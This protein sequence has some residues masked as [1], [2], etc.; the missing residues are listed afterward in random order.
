MVALHVITGSNVTLGGRAGST[1]TTTAPGPCPTQPPAARTISY[2]AHVAVITHHAHIRARRGPHKRRQRGYRA[3]PVTKP[4]TPRRYLPS[5]KGGRKTTDLRH[6]IAIRSSRQT[7]TASIDM[8]TRRIDQQW[9][10]PTKRSATRSR[11]H[12][13]TRL[14]H[15][16]DHRHIRR[17]T[18]GQQRT[19]IS[20]RTRRRDRP[21]TWQPSAE[22]SL[23]SS[24]GLFRQRHV[25]P[26]RDR[27]QR[28]ERHRQPR[29]SANPRQQH[30]APH[31]HPRTLDH[32]ACSPLASLTRRTNRTCRDISRQDPTQHAHPHEPTRLS[33]S[34]CSRTA[35]S[36]RR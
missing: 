4:A 7:G 19:I 8:R 22:G 1:S 25:L 29:R 20:A 18:Y 17:R 23:F 12:H 3:R 14:H 5:R 35:N 16:G 28:G 21:A 34:S 9:S 30:Q 2:P 24:A 36:S 26:C 31:A 6:K 27:N 13:R 33:A 32:A 15:A 11:R 10:S